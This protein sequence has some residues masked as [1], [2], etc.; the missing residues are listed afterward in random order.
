M[1]ALQA[2]D[3]PTFDRTLQGS[4]DIVL[5]LFSATYCQPCHRYKP[6]V[7]RVVDDSAGRLAL[8]V[9]DIE[10][11]VDLVAKYDVR[12]VPTLLCFAQGAVVGR[13]VG[14]MLEPRLRSV[15]R[16]YA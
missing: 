16:A 2:L 7:Q 14:A 11:S 5:V 8:Q 1:T 6:V 10:G 12:S 3:I 4:A 9:V 15:L 13:H